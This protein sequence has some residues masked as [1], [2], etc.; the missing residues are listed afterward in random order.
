MA[1]AFLRRRLQDR[2][3]EADVSSAGTVSDGEPAAEEVLDLMRARGLDVS[4]HASRVMSADLLASADLVVGMARV[5]VREATVLRP[6]VFERCF[7]LKELVRRGTEVGPRSPD[8]P[9]AFWL[10]RVGED[11][12]P[13]QLIG[14]AEVDDVPDPIGRRMGVY[15]KTAKLID[16]LTDRLVDLAFP[17]ATGAS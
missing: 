11:R 17:V 15:K 10:T 4:S 16:G 8:E 7:T 12:R 9:L 6:D 14:D 2:H 1:E 5:H 3:I 13:A